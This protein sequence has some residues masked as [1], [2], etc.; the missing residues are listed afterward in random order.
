ML[1]N[2][3]PVKFKPHAPVRPHSLLTHPSSPLCV[4]LQTRSSQEVPVT[5]SQARTLFQVCAVAPP[6]SKLRPIGLSVIAL[7][8]H[9]TDTELVFNTLN[10]LTHRL[11][12]NSHMYGSENKVTA[13]M[14]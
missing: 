8:F 11:H 6:S 2:A 14:F 1:L 10:S 7:L 12:C 5:M 4:C 3:R 13:G 9:N